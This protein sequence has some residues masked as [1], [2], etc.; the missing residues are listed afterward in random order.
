MGMERIRPSDLGGSEFLFEQMSKIFHD[1]D[2][3]CGS[4][5]RDHTEEQVII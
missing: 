4:K 3:C 1:D 5:F 2:G